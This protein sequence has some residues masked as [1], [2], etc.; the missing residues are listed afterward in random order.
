MSVPHD[1]PAH[2]DLPSI[3]RRGDLPEVDHRGPSSAELHAV[4]ELLSVQ[5]ERMVSLIHYTDA[6]PS[7]RQW[8]IPV[9]LDCGFDGELVVR[10]ANPGTC[11]RRPYGEPEDLRQQRRH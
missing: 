9:G 8:T 3:D 6:V 7:G 10:V 4:R 2:D 11:T 1:H 5:I